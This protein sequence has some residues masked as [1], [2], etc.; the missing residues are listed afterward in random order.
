MR[1]LLT[2]IISASLVGCT[3][4][5][6]EGTWKVTG[7]S[8]ESI[9]MIGD[10]GLIFKPEY[11]VSLDGSKMRITSEDQTL[12][13][14]Y[15]YEYSKNQLTILYSD[16]GIPVTVERKDEDEIYLYGGGWGNSIEEQNKSYFFM[17]LKKR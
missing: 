6:I 15:Y 10:G 1:I 12:L 5:N 13:E 9:T 3:S 17:V 14:E 7:T 11:K 4:I 16:F 8:G 2:I